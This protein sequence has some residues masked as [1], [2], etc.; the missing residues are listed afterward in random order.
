MKDVRKDWSGWKLREYGSTKDQSGLRRS[1]GNFLFY[2][3]VV[4]YI[5]AIIF[6]SVCSGKCV[7]AWLVT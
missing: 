7:P 1:L 4:S 5:L 3:P 2:V 6:T